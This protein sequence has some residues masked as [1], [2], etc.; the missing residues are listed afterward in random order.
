M[1]VLTPA[2]SKTWMNLTVFFCLLAVQPSVF[3]Q[4]PNSDTAKNFT[5]TWRLD[6]KANQSRQRLTAI[7]QATAGMGRFKQG[8][9]RKMLKKMTEPANELKIADSGT[10]I[11]L[12][13][14]GRE[15][16]VPTNGKAVVANG[17]KVRVTL[18]AGRRDGKLT[19]VSRT[20]NVTRTAVYEL[21]P[22]GQKLTQQIQLENSKL[23]NPIRFTNRFKR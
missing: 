8:R 6:A 22:D 13:R 17:D 16:T 3:A 14:A 12:V 11:K 10:Q 5:G 20:A 21:S 15:I 1:S 19:V 18:Q 7:E 4:T 2:N 23:P 9:A